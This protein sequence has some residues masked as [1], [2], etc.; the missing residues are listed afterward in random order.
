[1]TPRSRLLWAWLVTM[2]VTAAPRAWA[3]DDINYTDPK[4]KQ[5]GKASASSEPVEAEKAEQAFLAGTNEGKWLGNMGDT[6][7][8]LQYTFSGEGY[9]VGRYR[10]VSG[11]DSPERDP[12][13]WQVCGSNDGKAW[14]TLDERKDQAFA[15]RFV[16]KTYRLKNTTV[17]KMYRLVIKENNGSTEEDTGG[18]GIVQLTRWLLL[19]PAPATEET[20]LT[21]PDF[22]EQGGKA[23]ASSEPIDAEKAEQAFNHGTKAKW[24]GNMEDNGAWLQYTF[25][26]E[27]YAASKY[28]LIAGND[29]PERDPKQFQL[30]GSNDGKEWTTLDEQKDQAFDDRFMA[31][32]Y[33]IKKPAVFKIY[34]LVIIANNGST[35]DNT[36]GKGIVQLSELVLLK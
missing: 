20:I 11:N 8:W 17:Y 21:D 19:N 25:N 32:T 28:R 27:G 18:K 4:D 6:G 9:A 15:D 3:A 35:E 36:G 33:T 2:L 22:N 14:T 26:K 5:A 13:A 29:A 10:L 23:S 12:K 30:R 16:A 7:A 1:M 31:K 34:R 24:L